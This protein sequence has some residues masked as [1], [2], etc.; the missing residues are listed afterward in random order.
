MSY[1]GMYLYDQRIDRFR[2]LQPDDHEILE[3]KTREHIEKL[4]DL[5]GYR[6]PIRSPS[7]IFVSWISGARRDAPRPPDEAKMLSDMVQK[8]ERAIAEHNMESL[9][10]Y[11]DLVLI[12]AEVAAFRIAMIDDLT[13][14]P[15]KVI[16]GS[17]ST[18]RGKLSKKK[19][20]RQ[21][22]DLRRVV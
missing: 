5:A 12:G 9:R 10:V 17:D 20:T 11:A 6:D 19:Q 7:R 14:K 22:P 18:A 15:F 16:Q 8:R 13:R 3:I 4:L 1:N 2:S 21:A